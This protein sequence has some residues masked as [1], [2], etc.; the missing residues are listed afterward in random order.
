MQLLLSLACMQREKSIGKMSVHYKYHTAL[1]C[2]CEIRVKEERFLTSVFI[3]QSSAPS[4]VRSY[5]KEGFSLQRKLQ[6]SA[7]TSEKI[8]QKRENIV[9]V[10]IS[11]S[12]KL[13]FFLGL[14]VGVFLL[15]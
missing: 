13:M 9:W 12:C 5:R 10:E 14:F 4:N 11:P 8:T 1:V 3:Y 6:V 2:F 15:R 7:M